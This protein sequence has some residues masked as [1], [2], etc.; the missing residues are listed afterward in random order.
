[1]AG[2]KLSSQNGSI[3]LVTNNPLDNFTLTLPNSSGTLMTT[4]QANTMFNAWAADTIL[5][6]NLVFV[7]G[8][9]IIDTSFASGI[10]QL[11]DFPY[12]TFKVYPPAG[13]TTYNLVAFIPSIH[14]VYFDGIVN[15][16]DILY[17][18]FTVD[19]TN[20][21]ILVQAGN[22]E[23]RAPAYANYLGVWQK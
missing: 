16:D 20:G 15:A 12:N 2:T 18:R 1:M 5:K 13:F 9:H 22:S 7:S 19:H 14:A 4:D 3:T 8:T 17:C 6:E 23:Q 10:G 11:Y 21:Y